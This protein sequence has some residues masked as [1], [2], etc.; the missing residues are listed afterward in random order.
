VAAHVGSQDLLDGGPVRRGI[1]GDALQRIDA[2]QADIQVFAAELVDG[3]GVAVGDL[4]FAGDAQLPPGDVGAQRQHPTGKRLQQRGPNVVLG[5]Q[6]VAGLVEVPVGREA[7]RQHE[8]HQHQDHQHTRDRGSPAG[9]PSGQPRLEP[10]TSGLAAGSAEDQAERQAG[11]DQQQQEPADAEH[12]PGGPAQGTDG[13]ADGI[14]E[15]LA[16]E[17]DTKDGQHDDQPPPGEG[18]TQDAA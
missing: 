10:A 12:Q 7:W 17:Q 11:R 3:L 1:T 4:A 6:L 16:P 5:L 13:F 8:H 2:A 18:T 14:C 15:A 9:R